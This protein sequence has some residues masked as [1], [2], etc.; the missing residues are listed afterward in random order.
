M[1]KNIPVSGALGTAALAAILVFGN[2]SSALAGTAFTRDLTLGASGSDVVALQTL[3]ITQGFSIPAGA[4]GYFGAQTKAALTSYQAAH[5]IVPAAGYFGPITRGSID[6]PADTGSGDTGSGTDTDSTPV[7]SGGEATLRGFDLISGDDLAVGDTNQEIAT[8]KFDVKS[9]DVRVQRLTLEFTGNDASLSTQPWR[10]IDR[11]SVYDGSKKVGSIDVG[12]K[13]DWDKSDSTYSVDIPVDT[14]IKAGRAAELSIRA[15]AQNSIDS[16]NLSQSFSIVVPD[17]G[18]RAVD[19]KGIQQYTGKD[20]DDVTLAFDREDNGKLSL[21]LSSDTPEAGVI[22]TDAKKSSDKT[23]AL[24]FEIR[25]SNDADVNLNE[26]SFRVDATFG[27]G[28][29]TGEDVNDI[30]RRATLK[31]DGKTYQGTVSGTDADSYEGTIT[32][33]KLRTTID[34]ND[35]V[36]GTLTIE[37]AG[38]ANHYDTGAT[39]SFSLLA[40]DTDAEGE[41]SGDTTDVN[42]SAKGNVMTVVGDAGINVSG[43]TNTAAATVNSKDTSRSYGTFTLKFDVTATGDDVLVP[44]AVSVNDDTATT[45]GA[46]VVT[47]GGTFTGTSSVVMTSAAD[48]YNDDYFIVHEGDTKTFTVS[49]TISPDTEGFYNVGLDYVRFSQVGASSFEKLDV[50]QNKAQFHTDPI[51]IPR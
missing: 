34:G 38:S 50:N 43:R 45:T 19:P 46:G 4:T 36:D 30:I 1:K 12:S 40:A 6:M 23:D 32:F 11:L 21:R 7:L 13:N 33:K 14:V 3:L 9:G 31:L 2:A 26:L 15:D 22:V 28:S 51:F 25:N 16:S 10:Y 24:A 18:I 27:D 35:S 49:L 20:S 39:L 17:N 5:S 37:L 44:R 41:R 42:G 8:A 29:V 48:R 47:M